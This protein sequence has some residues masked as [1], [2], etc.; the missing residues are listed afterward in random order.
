MR[1]HNVPDF[2]AAAT[3]FLDEDTVASQYVLE[4]T[5]LQFNSGNM[6]LDKEQ[7][8]E[9]YRIAFAIPLVTA[10]V[11]MDREEVNR[12]YEHLRQQMENADPEY[13][14]MQILDRAARTPWQSLVDFKQYVVARIMVWMVKTL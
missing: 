2:V 11:M 13:Y 12:F 8:V 6:V 3:R 9:S 14:R 7:L 4:Q 10:D 1:S 5:K